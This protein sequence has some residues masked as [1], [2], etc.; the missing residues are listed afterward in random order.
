M[1]PAVGGSVPFVVA[2]PFADALF[3]ILVVATTV[4]HAFVLRST[5]RGMRANPRARGVWEWVWALLPAFAIA[6]LFIWTW[7][8]MHPGSISVTLP[9]NRLPPGGIGS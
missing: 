2:G 9:A 5:L 8:E 6:A 3:F 7:A 1:C 4:A